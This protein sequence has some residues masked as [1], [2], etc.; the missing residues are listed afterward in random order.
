MRFAAGLVLLVSL[1][2]LAQSATYTNDQYHI[3]FQYPTE[4]TLT[5]A[6]LG[7]SSIAI[8]REDGQVFVGHHE[9]TISETMSIS[10]FA[11]LYQEISIAASSTNISAKYERTVAGVTAY[12]LEAESNKTPYS[13]AQ[14]RIGSMGWYVWCNSRTHSSATF[15]AFEQILSTFTFN[16]TTPKHPN[17]RRV[18]GATHLAMDFLQV[19]LVM[20]HLAKRDGSSVAVSSS[21]FHTM[22]TC[23]ECCGAGCNF[24]PTGTPFW[25]SCCQQNCGGHQQAC[26]SQGYGS[27]YCTGGGGGGPMGS[28][29]SP[30][31]GAIWCGS[32]YHT[33]SANW[34]CDVQGARNDRISAVNG[35]SVSSSG[36]DNTGYGDMVIIN[37]GSD[38]YAI[39]AHL[40]SRAVTAGTQV[41]KGA[42]VGGMGNSGTSAVHLHFHLRNGA[43]AGLNPNGMP[44]F[45]GNGWP[46]A[47]TWQG[48]ANCASFV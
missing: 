47:G 24:G 46:S 2:V 33:G 20:E 42:L 19:P 28:F 1:A 17:D 25:C 31:A 35:G 8:E 22:A 10:E 41:Q 5:D 37:H 30:K 29:Q 6:R 45:R 40:A 32:G 21:S 27:S 39:Y 4:W 34:A 44:G 15:T 12:V 48:G 38:I 14:L 26:R 43:Y 13:V 23:G 9:F 7:S 16:A 18:F 3:V 11:N 36:W